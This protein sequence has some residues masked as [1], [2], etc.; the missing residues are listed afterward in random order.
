[1]ATI[2][3]QWTVMTPDNQSA[4]ITS[5]VIFFPGPPTAYALAKLVS[6]LANLD[7]ALADHALDLIGE[8]L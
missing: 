5:L 7:F 6:V 4:A 8:R 3:G 1:V 2:A